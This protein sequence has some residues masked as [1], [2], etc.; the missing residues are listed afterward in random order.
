MTNTRFSRRLLLALGAV[1]LAFACS[2][3]AAT[4]RSS[5]LESHAD[6]V[7]LNALPSVARL[8]AACDALRNLEA[9]ADD[10][11]ELP[12]ERQRAQRATIDREWRAVDAEMTAYLGLPAFPREREMY[13]SGVPAALRDVDMALARLFSRVE[14]R[15]TAEARAAGERDV[16]AATNRAAELLRGLIRLNAEHADSEVRTVVTAHRRASRDALLLDGLAAVF[17]IVVGLWALRQFRKYD[18][19][20]QAHAAVVERRADEL[21]LFGKRVAHDLLSPLSALTYCLG[22]FKRASESDPKLQDALA[23]ARACVLRAQKMIRRHLRIRPCG[24]QAGA[25]RAV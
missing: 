16:G 8:T 15:E 1:A 7:A 6:A 23:R 9:A 24:R 19:L 10:F 18:R 12:A 17:G 13:E 4:W 25:G 22:A 14:G 20:L 5:E 21:E 11:A 3:L 2:T